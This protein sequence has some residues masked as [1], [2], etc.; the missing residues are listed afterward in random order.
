MERTNN[1]SVVLFDGPYTIARKDLKSD[2]CRENGW[3]VENVFL[4]VLP[5]TDKQE[6]GNDI[7]T[8]EHFSNFEMERKFV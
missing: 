2:N 4:I 1:T 6:G 5:K 7:I 8:K 3:V